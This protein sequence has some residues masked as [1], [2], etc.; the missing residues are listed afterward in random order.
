M[1]TAYRALRSKV[2]ELCRQSKYEKAIALCQA[3]LDKTRNENDRVN[4]S[5]LIPYILECEGRLSES[6]EVLQ[7]IIDANP[8]NRGARHDLLL[9]LIQ[10]GNFKQA[11]AAADRLVEIDAKF[12]FQSFTS[13]AYFHK[14]YAACKLRHFKQAKAALEK[15]DEMGALWI[16]GRLISREQLTSCISSKKFDLT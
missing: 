11:N 6:K 12:P 2:F 14:A 9:V 10:L 4:I 5:L 3:K 7:S 1:T 13:S 8:L 16:D 15:S